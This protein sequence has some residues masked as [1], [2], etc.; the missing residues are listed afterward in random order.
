MDYSLPGSSVHG[1]FQARILEWVA[2]SFSRGSSPPSDR[3]QV[4]CIVGRRFYHLSQQGS[5]ISGCV[6]VCVWTQRCCVCYVMSLKWMLCMPIERH[7]DFKEKKSAIQGD[8]WSRVKSI[9][10][11]ALGWAVW[12]RHTS[13][14]TVQGLLSSRLI[15]VW[16]SEVKG[17]GV[18]QSCP[19]LCDSMD[20]SPLGSSVHRILQ[21][22]VVEWVAISFSKRYPD[23]GIKPGSP[24]LQSDTL[25]SE[26][27]NLHN[28]SQDGR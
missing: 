18:A 7:R 4:S 24:A 17:S 28:S 23:P 6:C 27:T 3:T 11:Q 21:A 1:I 15:D 20:C 13:E 14:I 8:L 26:P 25:P 2:I 9:K 12:Y 5:P 22:R 16:W 19:T 10:S